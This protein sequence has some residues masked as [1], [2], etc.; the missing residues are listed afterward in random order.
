M[1]NSLF[2]PPPISSDYRFINPL[3]SRFEKRIYIPLP[4]VHGRKEMFRI[5]VGKNQHTL[6]DADFKV[7]HCALKLPEISHGFAITGVR[8]QRSRS[9]GWPRFRAAV[10]SM[11]FLWI[12]RSVEINEH[13]ITRLHLLFLEFNEAL[14]ALADRTDGYSGYDINILIKVRYQKWAPDS[15]ERPISGVNVKLVEISRGLLP[16][17][18][19]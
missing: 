13:E 3:Y 4:D 6:S 5:D 14:Q 15:V 2:S 19:V 8:T 16:R 7:R 9:L 10:L 18:V 12:A 17:S 1:I 11:L